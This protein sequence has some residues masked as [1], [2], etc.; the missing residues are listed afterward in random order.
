MVIVRITVRGSI[1]S[2][3]GSPDEPRT[4]SNNKRRADLYGA[5]APDVEGYEWKIGNQELSKL[6]LTA[7]AA[8]AVP[9]EIRHE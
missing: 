4:E 8:I 5:A 2:W 6:I 7:A 3:S 9:G 1:R